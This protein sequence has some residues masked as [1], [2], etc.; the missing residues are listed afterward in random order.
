MRVGLSNNRENKMGLIFLSFLSARHTLRYFVTASSQI[1][2]LPEYWEVAYVDGVQI[3][4][5]DSNS[6]KTKTKL[7]WVNKIAAEDPDF[8]EQ[9]LRGSIAGEQRFKVNI[10]IAKERFNQTGGSFSARTT[11]PIESTSFHHKEQVGTIGWLQR[12]LE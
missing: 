3:L 11:S 4:Q 7:D 9:E 6:R 12:K 10:E 1:T 2:K 8:W 5:F